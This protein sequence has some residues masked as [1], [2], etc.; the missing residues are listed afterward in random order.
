MIIRIKLHTVIS[1][2]FSIITLLAFLL[3][4]LLFKEQIILYLGLPFALSTFVF[5]Y[6]LLY[7]NDKEFSFRIAHAQIPDIILGAL[8]ILSVLAVLLVPA[9]N[10][11]MLEWMKISPL[12]WLR[13]LSSLLLTSFLPGYSLLKILDRKH[14]LDTGI[15]IVLSCLVSFFITFLAGFSI[16]V[17]ANSLDSL[18]LP[19]IIM[20]NIFLIIIY[21]LTNREKT[22]NHLL[23]VNWIELGLILSILTVITVGS[24]ITT[25]SNLPLTCG[26]MQNHYGTALNFLKGFPVYG[27]KMVTYSGGYLFAIYLDVVFILSGI[28]LALAEQCLYI[29]SFLPILAFYSSIKAWF[30]EGKDKRLP[31]VATVLSILLGFGGLYALY[32]KFTDPA[33]T[34]I[35][36]LLSTATSKTY[37][38]YMR[39]IYLPDIV[40]PL[41]NIGLPVFFTLLYFLKKNSSNLIRATII[42]VLVAL[43][44]MGHPSEAIIFIIIA[45]IYALSFRKNDDAKIGSYTVLG[46]GVVA[47]MNLA[48]PVQVFVSSGVGMGFSL[49]FVISLI[50]AVAASV[51]E[52]VKAKRAFLFLMNIR[53]SF[54]EKLGKSW[55]YGKWVLIYIYVFF[56]IVWL[57]IEKDFNLWT[58]GGYSFTPFFVFPLRFGVVG[59]LAIISIFIYFSEI[60]RDRRLFF[61]LSLIPVG[62]ALEQLANY[63]FTYYPAYRYGTLAFV[64]A[65]IIAAYGIIRII[66]KVQRLLKVIVSVLLVFLMI[67]GMLTTAL[68]YVNA[69]YYSTNSKISQDKLDALDYIRQNIMTNES[70]LTFATES[71]TELRNF[72]GINAVQDAQRWS[73]LLLS[74]SNPYIITYILSSSNIKYIYV[75]QRDVKLLNPSTLNSIVSY[76]P[77]VFKNDYATI[78]EVPTLTAPSSQA[79]FG[80]LQ[81]SHSLQKLENATW[82]DD[83]FTKGWYPYRQ[84]GEAK[85]YTSQVRNGIMEISVT[86]NQSGNAWASYALSGL[87]LNT[88]IYSVLSF[89]YK[90]DNAYTW[91]TIQLRNA[92]NHVF[93]SKGHMTDNTFTTISY[94]LPDDQVISTVEIIVETTDKASSG[95]SAVAEI[96]YIEISL[97]PFSKDDI[98]PALFASLLHAKYSVLYVDDKMMQNLEAYLS[99]YTYILL[100]SDPPTAVNGLLNWVSMGHTLVVLNTYGNGFFAN[101]LGINSSS[102][103]LSINNINS[104][105]VLYINSFLTVAAEKESEMLQPEF[106]AEIREYLPS[107]ESVPKVNVLPVYNSTSGSMQIKGD[108]KVDTDILIL[109]GTINLPNSPF[110]VNESKEIKIFGKTDFT[111]KN[112]TLLISPSESYMLIKPESYPIEG[113]VLVDD[114]KAALIVADANVIYNSDVPISF[115]FKTTALSLYARLPSIK[116]SGTITFDQL[117][118]HAALYVPLAGIVQQRTEIQGNVKFDTMYISSPLTIFSTFHAEG[119]ILNLAETTSPRPTIP[120]VE[121]LASFYNL[122]FNA[123]FVLGIASYVIIKRRTKTTIDE[124]H[125]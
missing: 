72:A 54:S 13:Y 18:G 44:Y 3:S 100:T 9:Y 115:K 84:Y 58:W 65:C 102:P 96:D 68:F 20:T 85:N 52:L 63:Y 105:K 14:V 87:S 92:S 116:V 31:L 53:T 62:F 93:F 29:F 36:Q 23:T 25:V 27:G 17:S 109:Q 34:D 7:S 22:R 98:F 75:T 64:G 73:K 77:Q 33:Y 80:V 8:I 97:S 108:L 32:L 69:S 19:I 107:E 1:L 81:F 125:E 10:G 86:S 74:T 110:S 50:L 6:A 120:W 16:L 60:I 112:A 43:G 67:S 122:T 12:N 90:V 95:Q 79:S 47:L 101:L 4:S 104:G 24:V 117:D 11:S 51:A 59:L 30:N 56:F 40:A 46:L 78:Y 121:V 15:V 21:Y 124:R 76:F 94:N 37:D 28:P 114:Q 66:D 119:K 48:A 39:I 111:I 49:P 42:P 41:W 113:E 26:D 82:I 83:S 106:L 38:I 70:F 61:F 103:L 99:N 57:T 123:I 88:T 89:R 35:I 91:F 71:A 45:F 118:V 2:T 5:S 55:R